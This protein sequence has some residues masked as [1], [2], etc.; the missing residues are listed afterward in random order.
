MTAVAY[1]RCLNIYDIVGT[2]HG[3][4]LANVVPG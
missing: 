1:T 4:L 2:S 3:V